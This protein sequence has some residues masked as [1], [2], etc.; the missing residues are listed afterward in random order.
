[1]C[2]QK[3]LRPLH[4]SG[5]MASDLLFRVGTA[6]FDSRDPLTPRHEPGVWAG[7]RESG[8]EPPPADS[9]RGV[10]MSLGEPEG[11]GSRNWLPGFL[12]DPSYGAGIAG[13]PADRW[14]PYGP[15]GSRGR[16]K[17]P[18]AD[19]DRRRH[20]ALGDWRPD[21]R[22]GHRTSWRLIGN[23]PLAAVLRPQ[24]GHHRADG[25]QAAGEQRRQQRPG[26]VG[27]PRG[28]AARAC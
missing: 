19:Q 18:H 4:R 20:H 9:P 24:P 27:A 5:E 12:D 10:A 6:G 16:E 13:F 15:R 21:R 11:G 7:P 25:H 17:V 8:G 28:A 3:I 23:H 2:G 22:D 14:L 1:M 26:C